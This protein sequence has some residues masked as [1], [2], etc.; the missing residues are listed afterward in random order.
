MFAAGSLEALRADI[1]AISQSHPEEYEELASMVDQLS[2][3]V[4]AG[5]AT[6]REAESIVSTLY[7]A[8][9]HIKTYA[10]VDAALSAAKVRAN[11]LA[12]ETGR[13]LLSPVPFL[14]GA[15]PPSTIHRILS[16]TLRRLL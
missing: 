7:H 1:E 9:H 6:S 12:E 14:L 15:S 16:P 4:S 3:M 10:S 2:G 5:T 13:Y 8:L 11:A